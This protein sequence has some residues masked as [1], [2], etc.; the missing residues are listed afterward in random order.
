MKVEIKWKN[1]GMWYINGKEFNKLKVNKF[2]L[3]LLYF[4]LLIT[5]FKQI[6]LELYQF[7]MFDHNDSNIFFKLHFLNKGL[8]TK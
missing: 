7:F 5:M 4:L 2:I 8:N 6:D 1:L 3:C